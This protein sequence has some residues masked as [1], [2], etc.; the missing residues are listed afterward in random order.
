MLSTR[1]QVIKTK[2]LE[3]APGECGSEFLRK[4]LTLYY[5]VTGNRFEFTVETTTATKHSE[6]LIAILK[7][8]KLVNTVPAFARSDR[9]ILQASLDPRFKYDLESL[10]EAEAVY[11]EG[12]EASTLETYV[13]SCAILAACGEIATI[14]EQ[15]VDAAFEQRLFGLVA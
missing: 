15:V 2:L 3:C 9:L 1:V 13:M 10:S 8:E 4:I 7:I 6:A 5:L 12:P 14:P 11:D